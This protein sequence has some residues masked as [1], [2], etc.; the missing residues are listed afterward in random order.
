M[1]IFWH[2]LDVFSAAGYRFELIPFALGHTTQGTILEYPQGQFWRDT[3]STL[4]YTIPLLRGV[5]KY[6]TEVNKYFPMVLIC[7]V[8]G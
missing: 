3:F 8:T 4:F 6:F 5:E 2:V 7:Q 1:L